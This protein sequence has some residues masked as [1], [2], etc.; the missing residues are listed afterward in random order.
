MTNEKLADLA[1]REYAKTMGDN[2]SMTP[3]E[4]RGL[5]GE[6]VLEDCYGLRSLNFTP[7]VIFDIGANIGVF[8]LFARECFP[9]AQIIAVEP[10][11]TNFQNLYE[12]V[13]DRNIHLF[14][15]AISPSR[16][17]WCHISPVNGAHACYLPL[18]EK[19]DGSWQLSDVD[20]LMLDA[21]YRIANP[22]QSCMFKIDCEGAEETILSHQP[23]LSVLSKVDYFS[24]E[25]HGAC[26]VPLEFSSSH[27]LQ[28][29]DNDTIVSARKRV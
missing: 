11:P 5:Y 7:D 26:G 9:N 27:D 3:A 8:S 19:T 2:P 1:Q 13:K 15:A 18:S 14:K 28:W 4:Y 29:N 21:I 23:S 24:M 10:D 25:V 6:V 12:R 20:T 17:C 22:E 16:V